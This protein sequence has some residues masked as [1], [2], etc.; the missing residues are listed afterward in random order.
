LSIPAVYVD[1]P[2]SDR[3]PADH[4]AAATGDSLNMIPKKLLPPALILSCRDPADKCDG[5]SGHTP[6]GN[7]AFN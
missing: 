7:D 3:S 1:I 2:A 6:G 4:L 5:V